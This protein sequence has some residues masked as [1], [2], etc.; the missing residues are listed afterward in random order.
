M[1]VDSVLMMTRG[2]VRKNILVIYNKEQRI[3]RGFG[4][5]YWYL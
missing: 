5:K 3:E 1:A 2:L 4:L